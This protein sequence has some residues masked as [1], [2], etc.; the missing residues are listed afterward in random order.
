MINLNEHK[1]FEYQ[2]KQEVVPLDIAIKAVKEA[3]SK[4]VDLEA[5]WNKMEKSLKEIDEKI[6]KND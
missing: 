2:T 1:F 4:T 5:A 6:I 3:V